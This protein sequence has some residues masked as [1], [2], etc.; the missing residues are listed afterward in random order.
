M[1]ARHQ[2]ALFS[3]V[4]DSDPELR[5]RTTWLTKFPWRA[6]AMAAPLVQIPVAGWGAPP[7]YLLSGTQSSH[8]LKENTTQ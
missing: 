2:W 4:V 7:S 3:S 5:N 6:T 1:P 8:H